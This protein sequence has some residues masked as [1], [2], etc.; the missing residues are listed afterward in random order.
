VDNTTKQSLLL[1]IDATSRHCHS[2]LP[3]LP[4]FPIPNTTAIAAAAAAAAAAA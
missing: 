2:A 1:L 3:R 4:C